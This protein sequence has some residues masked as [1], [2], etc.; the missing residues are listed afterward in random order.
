MSMPEIKLYPDATPDE[1]IAYS[2]GWN[3]ATAIARTEAFAAIRRAATYA[4][5]MD[6]KAEA[7]PFDLGWECADC[8]EGARSAIRAAIGL[9]KAS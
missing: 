3:T 4:R 2:M 9:E 6:K 8:A 1:Q 7:L 5:E